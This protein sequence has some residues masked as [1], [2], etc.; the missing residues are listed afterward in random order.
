M[1]AAVVYSLGRL[2]LFALVAVALW[3]GAGLAG[4][5]LNGLPL[6]LASLL[7]SSVASLFLLARQREQFSQA[8]VA[9]RA[10]KAAQIAARRARLEGDGAAP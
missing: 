6:L 1:K 4:L 5:R 8:L 7:L 10:D 3:G 9:K 2:G